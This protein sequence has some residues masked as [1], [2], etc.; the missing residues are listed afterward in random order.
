MATRGIGAKALSQRGKV[1]VREVLPWNEPGLSRAGRVIAFLEDLPITA[2]KLAGSKMTL[3]PWQCEFIEEVYAENGEGRR[4]IRT[5]VLSMARKNGKTQLAAG[6]ALCH[7]MGPEAEPRG[8][9]YSAALTRDQAAKL[10]QEMRAILNEHPELDDRANIIQFNKQIEVLTG[11]GAGSIYAALSA[12]AGS[13]MGL[14]PSFVVYDEL[15]SAPNRD[16]FDA[17]DT[18]TGARDNPLMICISTQAAADHHVFSELID[19]GTR[20]NSGDI[21][22]PSFH[23]TLYAAPADADPWSREAWIAANPAL[24]DFRS[25]EDVERQA[26]Q[27]RLVPSKES[28]FRNLILNQRVS[29]VSRFIHKAE[30]DRCNGVVDLASLAGRE[31]YG[32]L[33]L[34]G[35]RDLTAFVL[36]FPQEGRRFDVV[37]QFFMPEANIA[38]RSNEDRV[39]YELW[40][41]QG[42]ITLISGSTIDPGFVAQAIMQAAQTYDLRTVAYDRWRI[43]DLKRELGL[44]GGTVPLEPFGQG[45]KDM[46][47]AVDTL[48]RNVAEQLL[49][50]GGNPVLNMCSS[51]AVVT[52]DPAGSRKLDKSKATGR[53]DG[54]VALAM[55]L[56]VSGRHEPEVLPAWVLDAMV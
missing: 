36:V 40:A 38:E 39:P 24:A 26:S 53:I 49:R 9:V 42:F 4:P 37:C 15:G 52:R 44:F 34:S 23:L 11:D 3:R 51:N 35:S 43:E 56:Q 6:L 2:G 50:H 48:E 30:W 47:P 20:V 32:G 1:E 5:A 33:D 14:S 25:L 29:A 19:Y 41:R 16:L 55:A 8:E 17:L 28:A 12:D 54:L 21:Q 22:D 13:K 18:A 46:S 31:C 27:A 45:Y 10:F 7:L